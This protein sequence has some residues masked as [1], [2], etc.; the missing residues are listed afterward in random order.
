MTTLPTHGSPLDAVM[1]A[2]RTGRTAE[3]QRNLEAVAAVLPAWNARD[4][5]AVL[6]H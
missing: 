6:R 5:T 1:P 3:E 2:D 4:V